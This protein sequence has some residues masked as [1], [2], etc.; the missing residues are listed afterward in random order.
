[1]N[2]RVATSRYRYLEYG[3][4]FKLEHRTTETCYYLNL[5]FIISKY[6]TWNEKQK[7][8]CNEVFRLKWNSEL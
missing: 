1:M 4:L 6:L 7:T 5:V 3:Y 2:C 8:N